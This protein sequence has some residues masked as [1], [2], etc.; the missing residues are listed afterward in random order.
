MLYKK[1]FTLIELLVV[2]SII[3][4][5]ISIL[6]PALSSARDTARSSVCLNNQKQIMLASL[7]YADQDDDY[8]PH[9]EM[10]G[11]TNWPFS[12][13]NRGYYSWGHKIL[14]FLGDADSGNAAN[15]MFQCPSAELDKIQANDAEPNNRDCTYATMTQWPTPLSPSH[16]ARAL[17]GSYWSQKIT[18]VPNP[19]LSA[20]YIDSNKQEVF[21]WSDPTV[22]RGPSTRHAEAAN[23]AFLDGHVES[24]KGLDERIAVSVDL[25]DERWLR[26]HMV[27]R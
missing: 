3:A 2:I 7:M 23:M 27:K 20:Y 4:L 15:Q 10:G 8:L 13:P 17:S 11:G 25:L 21:H 6:L 18:N 22:L 12:R 16:V 14:D 9:M 5:L 24:K 19:S 26:W 1:A